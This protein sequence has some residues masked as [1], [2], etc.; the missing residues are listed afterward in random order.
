[1][2]AHNIFFFGLIALLAGLLAGTTIGFTGAIIG[3]GAALILFCIWLQQSDSVNP[4]FL[5]SVFCLV[6]AVASFYAP[7]R[8]DMRETRASAA[9]SSVPAFSFLSH[10][11]D[12]TLSVF[13]RTLRGDQGALMSGLLIGERKKFSPTMIDAM[14]ISGTTHIVAL[15][16]YN[17]MIVSS[18]ALSF[19]GFFLTRRFA[20]LT[21]TAAII[22][23]VIMTG[24]APSLVRAAIL[25][26]VVLL[27]FQTERPY[28][29]RNAIA[30]TAALMAN[31]D[32]RNLRICYWLSINF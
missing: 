26:I 22:L 24:A 27:A 18:F 14:R 4:L 32:P 31:P 28:H 23:F 10:L 9:I 6:F 7:Y 15:S 16:G 8:V 13:D 29:P 25:G 30:L 5:A 19:F 20:F 12:Y 21:A 2:P 17:I 3:A 11:K 1:M